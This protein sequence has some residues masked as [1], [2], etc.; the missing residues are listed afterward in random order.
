MVDRG[1]LAKAI[2]DSGLKKSYIS[3]KMGLS[4]ETLKN[5]MTG[6]SKW[7]IDECIAIKSLLGISDAE[8]IAIFFADDV[9]EMATSTNGT[10]DEQSAKFLG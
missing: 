8:A 1:K 6:R 7:Y 3:E 4:V 2:R 10:A 5:K 9:A